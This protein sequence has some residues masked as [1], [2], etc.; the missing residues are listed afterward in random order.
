MPAE[1][2]TSKQEK[3]NQANFKSIESPID[4]KDVDGKLEFK[5]AK[6]IGDLELLINIKTIDNNDNPLDLEKTDS[7]ICAIEEYDEIPTIHLFTTN[8]LEENNSPF[9]LLDSKYTARVINIADIH[10][11][12]KNLNVT[13]DKFL[14]MIH[15][16]PTG[17]DTLTLKP[18]DLDFIY[19]TYINPT[20]YL[21]GVDDPFRSIIENFGRDNSNKKI[22]NI[23]GIR[24]YDKQ[25]KENYNLDLYLEY[26]DNFDT[27]NIQQLSEKLTSANDKLSNQV[28]I[29]HIR[30]FDYK[31][32]VLEF[33]NATNL[34]AVIYHRLSP[35][36]NIIKL[37]HKSSHTPS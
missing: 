17:K 2:L 10:K 12:I 33:I 18:D 29:N 4:D 6:A 11:M 20:Y 5:Y 34:K 37:A 27:N 13:D 22:K 32:E 26:E 19:V 28:Q 15:N 25:H 35:W 30:F 14:T 1:K 23:Y 16:G 31:K 36:E 9:R 21:G 8:E 7:W 24:T 3:Q